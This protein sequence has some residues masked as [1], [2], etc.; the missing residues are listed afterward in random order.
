MTTEQWKDIPG[1]E[2]LYQV[3]DQGRIKSLS[4]RRSGKPQPLTLSTL[5]SGYMQATLSKYGKLK[6]HYV[7]RLVLLAFVGPSPLTVN[8]LD[9]TKNNNCLSNLEYLSHT[10]N[11]HHAWNIGLC[12]PIIGTRPNTPRGEQVGSAKLTETDV[13]EI[14]SRRASGESL[15]SLAKTFEIDASVISLIS[16]RLAWKHIE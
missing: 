2:G 9:G 3:S 15:K 11:C 6:M 1:Y 5:P 14:R 13:R 16:R 8:H 7:H 12:K 4:F 10:E